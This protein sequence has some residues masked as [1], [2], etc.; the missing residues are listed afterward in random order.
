MLAHA[1][2]LAG[3]SPQQPHARSGLLPCS[4]HPTALCDRA[5]LP[6]VPVGTTPSADSS[7]GIRAAAAALSPLPGHA[8]SRGTGEASRGQR[9]SRPCRDAGCIQ[10]R[11]L[12]MEGLAVACPLAPT[13]PPLVSGACPSP[14]T[15]VPRC[16]QTPPRGDAL[17]RPLSF[18]AT[19]TWTGTFTPEHDR[20]HGTH[21][22]AQPRAVQRVGWSALLGLVPTDNDCF[23]DFVVPPLLLFVPRNPEKTQT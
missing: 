7:P 21:A 20:M 1:Q 6:S 10:H 8:T 3:G 2:A 9:A 16:L 18:G 22:K 14:R 5:G 15:F 17:A 23:C 4:R 13:V 11:P 19:H 12:W